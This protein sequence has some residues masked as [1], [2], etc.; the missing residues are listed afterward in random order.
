MIFVWFSNISLVNCARITKGL[1]EYL[2]RPSNKYRKLFMEAITNFLRYPGS[3]RRQLTFLSNYLP[4]SKEIGNH[5][6]EPFVG[7]GS[8]FFYLNPSSA[9]LADINQDLIELYQG[10]KNDPLSVWMHYQNFG[11][12][13]VEYN[14]VRDRLESN[15]PSLRAARIL[16]LNRTC[17]KGM[18][19]YN[20]QGKFNVGYGGEDRRWVINLDNLIHV[21]SALQNAEIRCADFEQVIRHSAP[22]DFIFIDPPYRPGEADQ[23]N[24]HYVW[25]TFLYK[26]HKRLAEILKNASGNGILWAIT[27]TSNPNI[28]ELYKGNWGVEFEIGTGRRP[29]V[30]SRQSGEILILNY[31]KEGTR[32]L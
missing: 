16:Y 12:N 18:W 29:G 11:Q 3:K 7:G 6:I 15:N 23:K 31:K 32:L 22:G 4:T 2:Q 26:D 5:Y 24:N 19:R 13:K 9:I 20:S 21:S 10:I 27:I 14:R 1:I 17:F 25:K 30:M 28:L 8:V